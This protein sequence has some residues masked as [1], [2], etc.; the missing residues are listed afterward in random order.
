MGA[1]GSLTAGRSGTNIEGDSGSFHPISKISQTVG[2][3]LWVKKDSAQQM[4]QAAS[5]SPACPFPLCGGLS[6][7]WIL[8]WGWRVPGPPQQVT[9]SCTSWD[10]ER[11]G[12]GGSCAF[13]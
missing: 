13:V 11:A 5:L 10:S 8:P 7:L 12:W 3:I 9:G 6:F 1:V 4:G 2:G